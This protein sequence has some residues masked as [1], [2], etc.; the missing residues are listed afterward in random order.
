MES[1][2]KII[3]ILRYNKQDELANLLRGSLYDFTESSS[4][5]SQ[6]N[7]YLTTV[8]IYSPIPLN[9]KLKQLSKNDED[10]IL[11]AFY[12][13]YPV[14][15]YEIEINNIE[16]FVDPDNP[17]PESEIIT[18]KREIVETDYW[19]NG[20]FRMFISHSSK[21]KSKANELS[22]A[23]ETYAIS[24]FVA[25]D[26][27]EPTK[28]WQLVI[29]D[30][31]LTCDGMVALLNEDFHS[32][33]WTDQEVGICYAANKIII[34]VRMGVNP[35]GFLGKYQ[36][37]SGGSESIRVIAHTIFKLLNNRVGTQE[38]ISESIINLFKN[39]SSYLTTIQTIILLDTLKY[40]NTD[41][42]NELK[43]SIE[44]NSQL[45][46]ANGVPEKISRFIK[47]WEEKLI[48]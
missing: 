29:E 31:L 21:I 15:A 42:L 6:Y 13:I 45:K 47:S 4:Y 2:E 30:A 9:E 10:Q 14:K 12:T 26:D 23:L 25:H 44:I 22:K 48:S 43:E 7:S 24:S 34:P 16:Y 36:G 28:E 33:L 19:K 37:V 1:C 5:G 38:K 40:I 35:Y 32:S 20:Y 11:K 3:I 46:E 18:T 27:I 41:L 8:N 17:I 39:S